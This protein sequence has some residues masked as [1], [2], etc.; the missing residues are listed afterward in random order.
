MT[1]PAPSGSNYA[2]IV[3]A[4]SF[5]ALE[6]VVDQAHDFC[7]SCC[8]NDDLTHKVML[9]TS[10]AVTNAMKHGNR[11]A[12]DKNVEI[13][14]INRGDVIEVWVEDEGEGFVRE[15]VPNPLSEEHLLDTGGRGIF[16]IERM[17]DEVR[18]ERDG[19]RVGMIFRK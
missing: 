19:R 6:K 12:E 2:K 15:D 8:D 14:F 18:Y 17:A 5:S 1:M 13:E 4:S 11:L 7:I 9:L 16:L 10:E 3:V